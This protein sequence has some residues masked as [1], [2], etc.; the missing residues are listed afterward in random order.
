MTSFITTRPETAADELRISGLLDRAFAAHPHSRGTEAAIVRALRVAGALRVSLVGELTG[1]ARGYIAA[2]S[3]QIAGITTGWYGL[4]P[5]AVDPAFQGRGLGARLITDCL[6]ELRRQSA[7]GCVVLGAPAYY[8]R[9]GFAPFAGLVY[10][11]PP[12][13]HFMA[14]SF[15]GSRPSGVVR[16]HPAFDV[17][18]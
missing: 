11:G 12:P 1:E 5:V 17:E 3:V 8:S 13:E 14:L 15:D 10:P 9:F 7:A 16:Y 6:A 2:S 4:G 18:A